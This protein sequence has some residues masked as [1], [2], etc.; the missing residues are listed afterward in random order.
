[1]KPIVDGIEAEFQ[2][3][4]LVIRVNVQSTAGQ[5]LARQ[6]GSFVTPTFIFFDGMGTIQWRSIGSLDPDQVRKH[7]QGYR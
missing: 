6:Y 7:M 1:M 2:N 3:K 4:L 5:S